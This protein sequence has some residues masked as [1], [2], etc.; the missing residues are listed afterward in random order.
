MMGKPQALRQRHE[1]WNIKLWTHM[2]NYKQEADKTKSKCHKSLNSKL[3][4]SDTLHPK[5][6]IS[7]QTPN[8]H[9]QLEAKH[10]NV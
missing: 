7:F 10:L 5:K 8:Q 6:V 2:L 9:H 4:S 1:G 3:N